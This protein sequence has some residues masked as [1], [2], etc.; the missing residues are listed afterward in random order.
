[1]ERSSFMAGRKAPELGRMVEGV[2]F[3]GRPRL[4]LRSPVVVEMPTIDLKG[5][6]LRIPCKC[7]APPPAEQIHFTF[8]M[9]PLH[10]DTL[11][12]GELS[13]M[14]VREHAVLQHTSPQNVA[15]KVE[16]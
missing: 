15:T 1:M 8:D 4:A 2:S 12:R 14:S 16:I 5:S 10:V 3:A 6:S 13:K 7:D 11:V 9:A